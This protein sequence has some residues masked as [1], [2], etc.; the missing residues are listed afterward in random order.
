LQ[1]NGIDQ[2]TLQ[3]QAAE[4]TQGAH[5]H[6]HHHH[7]GGAGQ[8]SSANGSQPSSDTYALA[9]ASSQT[10]STTTGTATGTASTSVAQQSPI[11]QLAD[12][13]SQI[14]GSSGSNQDQSVSGL[15]LNVQ[16]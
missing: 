8:T 7:G 14:S 16:T 2:Q 11:Q 3:Q 10:T 13:L 1:D 6:H 9:G 12:L 4:Q 15:L 5:H